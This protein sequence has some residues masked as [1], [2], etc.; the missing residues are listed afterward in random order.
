MTSKELRD[1]ANEL[2]AE[3]IRT[4]ENNPNIIPIMDLKRNSDCIPV[5]ESSLR[6]AYNAGIEDVANRITDKSCLS[7]FCTAPILIKWI[8][9][10]SLPEPEGK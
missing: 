5:I 6:R 4:R 7:C 2:F 9:A 8:R 3:I 1:E 10:L